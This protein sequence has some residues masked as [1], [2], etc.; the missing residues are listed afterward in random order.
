MARNK[1]LDSTLDDI[2][3]DADNCPDCHRH[4]GFGFPVAV[5]DLISSI[6]GLPVLYLE[7]ATSGDGH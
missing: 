1:R 7:R 4:D 3:H 5:D 6:D 2:L